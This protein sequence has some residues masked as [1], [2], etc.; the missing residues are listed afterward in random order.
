MLVLLAAIGAT[1]WLHM[2]IGYHLAQGFA[3]PL[4]NVLRDVVG[5]RHGHL[6]N[7]MLVV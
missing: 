4:L 3:Q 1:E 7:G 2:N 5:L 6:S